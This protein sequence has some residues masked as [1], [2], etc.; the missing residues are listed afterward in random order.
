M[1]MDI[2]SRFIS[3]YN[4]G[5]I[6]PP[7]EE[8]E[9][10][11]DE[12][13]KETLTLTNAQIK[14]LPTG[15]IDI[16]AA[17]GP[18]QMNQFIL[19]I[20]EIDTQAGAYTNVNASA[21]IQFQLAPNGNATPITPLIPLDGYLDAAGTALNSVLQ[22]PTNTGF[23]NS[24]LADVGISFEDLSIGVWVANGGDGNFTG[25]NEANTMKIT[26]IYDVIDL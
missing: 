10:E 2:G 3:R 16:V 14:A 6:N 1:T 25:G 20:I 19:G 11:G 5:R 18:G 13:M 17:P 4:E 9:T 22:D 26:V 12:F 7:P 24:F 15:A 8:E 23:G 21:A